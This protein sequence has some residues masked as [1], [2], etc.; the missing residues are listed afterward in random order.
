MWLEWL[1]LWA[2]T[3]AGLLVTVW[4]VPGIRVRDAGALLLAAV[5][6]LLANSFV[7]PLLLILTLPLTVL[8]FGLFVLVIN[9][10]MLMLTSALVPGFEVRGFGPALLG[11]IVMGLLT[12]LGLLLLGWLFPEHTVIMIQTMPHGGREVPF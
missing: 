3:A 1:F 11:A 2:A 4:I 10:L 9:A 8:T 7:R 6:L 12:L 5:I